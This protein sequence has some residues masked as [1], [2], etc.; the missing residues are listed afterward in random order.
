M[1]DSSRKD[2]SG[3]PLWRGLREI[4]SP[5]CESTRA[6][7]EALATAGLKGEIGVD[8][9]ITVGVNSDNLPIA[10][11]FSCASVSEEM[12][13]TQCHSL[14][15]QEMFDVIHDGEISKFYWVF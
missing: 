11:C 10:A 8:F 13:L 7:I 1:G 2:R 12:S 6:Q 9:S 5:T 15:V 14:L 3:A 4:V